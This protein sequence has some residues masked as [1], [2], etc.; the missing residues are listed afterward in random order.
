VQSNADVLYVRPFIPAPV[1][2]QHLCAHS[3][4][5][6]PPQSPVNEDPTMAPEPTLSSLAQLAASASVNYISSVPP[7][8]V[9]TSPTSFSSCSMRVAGCHRRLVEEEEV[10]RCEAEG[11]CLVFVSQQNWC[12]NPILSPHHLEI[13]D[14]GPYYCN[15]DLVPRENTQAWLKHIHHTTPTLLF[16]FAGSHQCT[17]LAFGTARHCSAS[18]KH[19][20]RAQHRASPSASLASQTSA[21][22][23]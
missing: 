16:R 6:S 23:V 7:N 21:K 9:S 19:K 11:K 8:S 13:N 1:F 10:R 3:P 20:N 14:I 22:A 2:D 18:S 4:S 5:Q 15:V 17:N 12:V